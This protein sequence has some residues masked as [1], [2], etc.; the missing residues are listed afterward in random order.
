MINAEV[1]ELKRFKSGC[2]STFELIVGESRGISC[3]FLSFGFDG[4]MG[5]LRCR[6]VTSFLLIVLA[7][8]LWGG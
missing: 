3:A 1:K 6:G 2:Y 4:P 8:L 5:L 7:C